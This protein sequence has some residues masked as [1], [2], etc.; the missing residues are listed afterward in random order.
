MLWEQTSEK[1]KVIAT[2]QAGSCQSPV[3]ERTG[4]R[5]SDTD[6]HHFLDSPDSQK[7]RLSSAKLEF[8]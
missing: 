6:V 8:G 3:E 7:G 4:L 2:R 1:H 5:L